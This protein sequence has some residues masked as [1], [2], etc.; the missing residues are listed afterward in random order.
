MERTSPS[1]DTQAG[2][3]TRSYSLDFWENAKIDLI[4]S[5]PQIH[6]LRGSTSLDRNASTG[7]EKKQR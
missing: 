2:L 4:D 5:G 1:F 7:T 3:V 6:R